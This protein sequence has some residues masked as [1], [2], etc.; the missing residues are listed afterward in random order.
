[1][2]TEE[3]TRLF[4]DKGLKATPQRIA[5]YRFLYENRIHPD[6]ET[7][8][9]QMIKGNPSFSK[10]TVYNCLKDLSACGLLIP[11]KIDA[12]KIRYDADT[13][14][15]GHFRCESCGK[16]YD[17]KCDFNV[18]SLEDFEIRQ[19]DV[20]YSGICSCCKNKI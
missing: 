20:Y 8:Y 10:T 9:Q 15:H 5:V 18:D 1:M 7:V 16:I 11:V 13:S 3:I 6:V 17:F 2:Q 4:R 19:R 12:D 14:F